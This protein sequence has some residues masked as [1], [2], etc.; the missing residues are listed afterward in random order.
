VRA[1]EWNL[2]LDSVEYSDKYTGFRDLG[3]ALR[4]PATNVIEH[5]AKQRLENR[6]NYNITPNRERS[7]YFPIIYLRDQEAGNVTSLGWDPYSNEARRAAMEEA[8]DTAEPVAT[9]PIPMARPS[10]EFSLTGQIV[11]FPVYR[12][13]VQ[14]TTVE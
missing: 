2:F 5:I 13:T 11:Y 7:E 10:G 14:P 8:R 3:F 12:A 9:P 4:V 6:A 1:E